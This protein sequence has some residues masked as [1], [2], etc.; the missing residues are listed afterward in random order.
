MS[1]NQ[2]LVP[3]VLIGVLFG[4]VA[5]V[6]AAESENA[7]QKPNPRFK[8]SPHK[9]HFSKLNLASALSETRSFTIKNTG[10]VSV[11]LTVGSSGVPFA[12]SGAG[13][14]VLAPDQS[15]TVMVSFQPPRA[16]VFHSVLNV[17]MNDSQTQAP[18]QS[19][20]VLC[21]GGANG[22]AAAP[23]A[24]PPATPT[25]QPT[26]IPSATSTATSTVTN[27]AT[28]T[29]TATSA[30]TATWTLKPTSTGWQ[31][32]SP[33]GSIICK[34]VAPSL[35][36][37]TFAYSSMIGSGGK[38]PTR[39]AW[40]NTQNSRLRSWGFTAAGQY[41][42]AYSVS[43]PA[44]GVPYAA[45]D[46]VSSWVTRDDMPWHIKNVYQ[47]PGPTQVCNSDIYYGIQADVFDPNA[48]ADYT[49]ALVHSWVNTGLPLSQMIVYFPEEADDMFGLDQNWTHVDLG[50]MVL[51]QNPMQANDGNGY[52]YPDHT[53]YSKM[54]LKNF[55]IAKYS[56]ISALN[57]AWGTHYTT[58]DTSDAGG[59]AGIKAGAYSSYG[60]GTGLL[61][62][63]GANVIATGISCGNLNAGSNWSSNP[64]I[65]TD[66]QN[67]VQSFAL[68]Y[69]Q[70]LS[71]AIATSVPNHPPV[72][73]PLYAA[74][75]YV[76]AQIAPYVDG[77][78]ISFNP[79][80]PNDVQRIIDASPK[81]VIVVDY[82][83]ANADS[84][85]SAFS[86]SSCPQCPP[87]PTQAARG[88]GEVALWKSILPLKNNSGL[89]GVVG[90]EHWQLYDN[91]TEKLDFGFVTSDH[92]NPYDGSAN[93]RNGEPG[94]YG[95]VLTPISNFLN[96]GVCDP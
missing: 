64:Q 7:A 9:I 42:Y 18:A 74:P 68:R 27:T 96:A 78:W 47:N 8:V 46:Q 50:Y 70:I 12:V 67:F 14:L 38:Y 80:A 41:S 43:V 71:T 37:T 35:V 45:T 85:L 53:L 52:T 24:T 76:Y 56:S 3:P 30:T 55:L 90:V 51:S 61:D 66:V 94:N 49:A 81:P 39:A 77:F 25:S 33:T 15:R 16:G 2:R 40:G 28:P 72:F 4:L 59:D 86:D 87:Y 19:K 54:A 17:T 65:E 60:N 23:P 32:V 57:A 44:G 1:R 91:N 58:F 34:Y 13:E 75:S 88:S 31:F 10:K 79:S 6:A 29:P 11:D 62:E 82:S 48:Q 20:R 73:L 83:V 93:M 95:D 69:A 36:D 92:D 5:L 22:A 89:Y 26:P 21:T 84:P 63:N